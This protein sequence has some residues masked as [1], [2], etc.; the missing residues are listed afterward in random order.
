MLMRF[1]LSVIWNSLQVW[2]VTVEISIMICL[3]VGH[4]Q[5]YLGY[6]AVT[7]HWQPKRRVITS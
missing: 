6:C 1:F 7:G 4:E 5:N 3:A 2:Y